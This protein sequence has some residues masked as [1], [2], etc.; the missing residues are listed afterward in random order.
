MLQ[1]LFSGKS[2]AK[3]RNGYF[4][5]HKLNSWRWPNDLQP[6]WLEFW[7]KREGEAPPIRMQLTMEDAK[8]LR[9]ALE[10]VVKEAGS[11]QEG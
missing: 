9:E 7:S 10:T 2:Q 4:V 6:V 8:L 5:L 1:T 3:G 11:H